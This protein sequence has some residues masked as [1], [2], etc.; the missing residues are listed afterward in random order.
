MTTHLE[1]EP[2]S[3]DNGKS[4]F[5]SLRIRTNGKEITTPVKALNPTKFRDGVSLNRDAFG[6]NETYKKIDADKI[7][8]L[9]T[10]T[11]EHDRF[12]AEMS[13]LHRRKH[14]TDLSICVL[15]F[16]SD[17][18]NRFPSMKEVE[19]LTDVAHSFSDITPIPLLG[20]KIDLSN[21][22]AYLEYLQLCYDTIEEL[23][24]KPIMG[25][26]PRIP[27]ELYSK[28]LEFYVKKQISSFC[29]DFDGQTPNDLKLRPILRYF[30]TN[31]ILDQ[32]LI[33]G[34]NARPGKMLKNTN[35]IPSK[36]FIAYG[37]G[38]DIL[39]ESHVGPKLPKGYF[40]K[41]RRAAVN[42]QVNKKRIFIKADYGYYKTSSSNE[43]LDFYPDDTSI[44]LE[45]ILHDS[46]PIME[47]LFNMEQQSLEAN[48]IKNGLS[49]LDSNETILTY[50]G[51]KVRIKKELPRF[52][53]AA[54]FASQTTLNI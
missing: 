5:R 23:N 50:V 42:Q 2:L 34:I 1:I 15:K 47:K 51:K 8:R 30:N 3:N 37:F 31:R 38:L 16:A 43:I 12:S 35:V 19:L 20:F 32:T 44:K 7:A 21:F 52:Q 13:N 24:N 41:L 36:D 18:P 9:L 17:K 40:E 53:M 4:L 33:Y 27:R 46:Q 22:S 54:R 39:G 25:V 45:D 10:D 6:F 14:P 28:L 11:Y 48:N 49:T 26:L 29:L